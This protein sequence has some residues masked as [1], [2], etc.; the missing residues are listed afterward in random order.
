MWAQMRS[1]RQMAAP[2]WHTTFPTRRP[3][4]LLLAPLAGMQ[5][6]AKPT[7]G[8][9]VF[10]FHVAPAGRAPPPPRSSP[11][12][13]SGRRRWGRAGCGVS[14]WLRPTL[15]PLQ[16]RAPRTPAG[17]HLR[18][19]C[20]EWRCLPAG[21]EAPAAG[22]A[23]RAGERGERPRL[24]ALRSCRAASLWSRTGKAGRRRGRDRL[25]FLSKAGWVQMH[26]VAAEEERI[27]AAAWRP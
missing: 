1:L 7:G 26:N 22:L 3:N 16:P 14:G 15:L 19:G 24:A 13:H 27:Y 17:S 6:A 11:A 4:S 12:I 8:T 5:L 10:E 18:A 25:S 2:G 23:S 20:G 9:K 21:E